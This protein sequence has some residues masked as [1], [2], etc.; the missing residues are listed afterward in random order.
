[1]VEDAV[2][3]LL[4]GEEVEVDVKIGVIGSGN[5]DVNG[6]FAMAAWDFND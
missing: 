2:A 6:T 5:R 3:C 4:V 1:M